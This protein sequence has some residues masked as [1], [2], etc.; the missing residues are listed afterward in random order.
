M[1][2]KFIQQIE[3]DFLQLW[4]K[5]TFSANNAFQDSDWLNC[6]NIIGEKE[7]MVFKP[8][9]TSF[10]SRITDLVEASALRSNIVP[11]KVSLSGYWWNFDSGS[12]MG[13]MKD[14]ACCALVYEDGQYVMIS[15][16]SLQ[17]SKL[18]AESA[19]QLYETAYSFYPVLDSGKISAFQLIQF[20]ISGKKNTLIPFLLLCILITVL[21]VVPPIAFS[22]L[23]G[24]VIPSANGV[25]LLQLGLALFLIALMLVVNTIFRNIMLVRFEHSV[26]K[27]LQ[28][29]ILYRILML[30]SRFFE[31]YPLGELLERALAIQRIRIMVTGSFISFLFNIL[32]SVGYLLLM[33]AYSS[34]LSN[35]ALF[36][37]LLY[38]LFIAF[39][40]RKELNASRS[41]L[42]V[43][44][45]L[46]GR[47][48]QFV[49]GISKIKTA[50]KELFMLREWSKDFLMERQKKVET[51][52]LDQ[53][54]QLVNFL[55]PGI[56]FLFFYSFS[57]SIMN[58]ITPGAFVGFVTAFGL[59]SAN[60]MGLGL[61]MSNFLNVIPIFK[62]MESIL[63]E[64]EEKDARLDE[65]CSVE[66]KIELNQVCYRYEQQTP[67]VLNGLSLTI[68]PKE[69]VAFVG[70]SGSGKSTIF[71][72]LLGFETP[73]AGSIYF[74]NQDLQHLSK[75]AIR[76]NMGVVMQN[77]ALMAGSIFEN[78]AGKQNIG[79]DAV[80]LALA[81][82]GIDKEVRD[83][84]MGLHT[85]ISDSGGGFSGGQ[86][87]RLLIARALVNNPKILLFDEAT[88][89]LDNISQKVVI[90]T[91]RNLQ[92]TKLVI[93]HRL[94]TI[95]GAD[96]VYFIGKGTVL[97]EGSP[98]E[99]LNSDGPFREFAKRQQR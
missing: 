86:R 37:L 40:Y 11:R 20:A 75:K 81:K 28:T 51:V 49:S 8:V 4:D 84:P 7:G 46:S 39:L 31:K 73:E 93:A 67:L 60:V 29:A 18:N 1:E 16:A 52:E 62:K 17:R 47:I 26:D 9:P 44:S 76:R 63:Q 24:N 74:D 56:T 71:R 72:L 36:S 35:Y 99:L 19:K 89:A 22:S 42:D 25:L 69:Y 10:D 55:F 98:Q 92:A 53:Q 12:L 90:E 34:Y 43:R 54:I 65:K 78:I 38:L 70:E 94:E 57:N 80:W 59:L 14:G 5:K 27:K 45:K 41:Y 48:F 95:M 3:S 33:Y 91:L 64:V 83:L 79:Y 50:G 6:L 21:N 77:S 97:Q 15:P 66:G 58:T 87:Q 61:N 96:K 88:S 13:F 68:K 85:V 32:F 23:I 82:V 2:K 30:P